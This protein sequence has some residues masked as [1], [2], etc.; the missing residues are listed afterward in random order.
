MNT[1]NIDMYVYKL[2]V[3]NGGAPCIFSNQLSLAIC[4][5][6]VRR[7]AQKGSLIFGF[8]GKNY[9]EKLLYIAK[10]TNKLEGK[11]YYEMQEYATRPDCIYIEEDGIAKLKS[12]PKPIYHVTGEELITDVGP[13][14][15]NA[16]V[17][18]SNDFRYFGKAGTDE[19]KSD[20]EHIKNLIES[21]KRGHRINYEPELREQLINLKNKI[22]EEHPNKMKI[23]NY[24][25]KDTRI[26]CN[27][28][29]VLYP[30]SIGFV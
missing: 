23:G 4:K 10:V 8:G 21:L 13:R 17:L 29:D 5:P 18:I 11:N 2:T 14:F 15:E 27:T 3:D 6:V 7:K 16:H 12:L 1:E 24:S 20:F 22:W 9:N 30:Q 28:E 25:E 26:K 19:Y